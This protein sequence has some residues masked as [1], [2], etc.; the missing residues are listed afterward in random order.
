GVIWVA[1]GRDAQPLA[2]LQQIALRLGDDLAKYATEAAARQQLAVR[3]DRAAVLIVLDNI[4]SR[5]PV[6]L[7]REALGVR[8][9]LLL[10][11]REPSVLEVG[12]PTVSL[13]PFSP[14]EALA[15]LAGRARAAGSEPTPAMAE[16]ARDCGYLPFALALA[17]AMI[18]STSWERLLERLQAADLRFMEAR[19]PG[20][21]DTDLLR[22]LQV[23]VDHLR[24]SEGER[25]R[26]AVDRYLEIAAFRWET[27]VPEAALAILWR[28]RGGLDECA[29]EDVLTRLARCGLV[30]A[31]GHAP[32]R[33][34]RLHDLQRD[35]LWCHVERGARAREHAAIV[36]AYASFAAGA[37]FVAHDDGYF[38]ENCFHHLEHADR[39]GEMHAIL[40]REA[41]DGASAWWATRFAHGQVLGFV[42]DVR[43]AS[44]H[45]WRSVS[46][47]QRPDAEAV[48]RAV[49]YALMIA[50]ARSAVGEV[51]LQLVSRLLAEKLWTADQALALIEWAGHGSG[52]IDALG[53]VF[54]YL[55][56]D[57]RPQAV[58]DAL[59][60]ARGQVEAGDRTRRL[61]QLVPLLEGASRLQVLE[62]ALGRPDE[63]SIDLLCQVV[64]LAP[65]RLDLLDRAIQAAR[66]SRE[67][68]SRKGAIEQLA[69]VVP[70]SRLD[71][72][73]PLVDGAGSDEHQAEVLTVLA[74]R[75]SATRRGELAARAFALLSHGEDFKGAGVTAV[76]ER[77][78]VV[79][80]L[81][82]EQQAAAATG[83]MTELE[84]LK[85]DRHRLV[86]IAD[87]VPF[88]TGLER[89]RAELRACELAGHVDAF[90]IAEVVEDGGRGRWLAAAAPEFC[91]PLLTA[92]VEAA[93]NAETSSR[94][95]AA[96][97]ALLPCLDPARARAVLIEEERHARLIGDVEQRVTCI[98]AL[99]RTLPPAAREP[100][101]SRMLAA[102][103][104]GT[105][106]RW[107]ARSL[108]ALAPVAA[109]GQLARM[110]AAL[111]TVPGLERA[112]AAAALF[113]ATARLGR[114]D[115]ALGFLP[116]L[117][118][119]HHLRLA[120]D[121]LPEEVPADVVRTIIRGAA[122]AK[123]A[124]LGATA[125][126]PLARRLPEDERETACEMGLRAAEVLRLPDRYRLLEA[127]IPAIP[128]ER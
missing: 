110:A 119:A 25:G 32:R 96:I 64:R 13:G 84:R 63:A 81:P 35:Y 75:L 14:D 70:S 48:A 42:A 71:E 74:E 127:L 30:R 122:D 83:V 18:A 107:S 8:C 126:A 102:I 50:S 68:F 77:A 3:L 49:R 39:A 116:E 105:G 16:V 97:A 101:V 120:L 43:R 56:P 11:A 4:W 21:P 86:A 52:R 15:Y 118:N 88:L 112:R 27:G 55:P 28:A 2:V 76:K 36:D 47:G 91:Q 123:D 125:I 114:W 67:A 124:E 26:T 90:H 1:V 58:A 128:C 82:P 115:R 79:R 93:R 92:L 113:A 98:G 78:R 99:T 85:S 12:A 53:A 69:G 62:E 111:S 54:P 106:G 87:V 65:D 10:T 60:L 89:T 108:A 29:A 95:I 40:A 38:L 20:Y 117:D 72:L 5:D 61:L 45:A 121:Q 94:R 109:A 46:V 23:S 7:V 6:K 103:A 59:Q 24:E 34:V 104:G 100:V 19:I 37:P 9:R 31:E 73:L 17:G 22:T 51:P 44:V 33:L 66:D 41:G 57:R 80:L